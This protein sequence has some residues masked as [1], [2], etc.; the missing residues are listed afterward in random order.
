MSNKF[1]SGLSHKSF[2]LSFTGLVNI[3]MQY[4]VRAG[5]R[6]GRRFIYFLNVASL[7]RAE[8]SEIS[9]K[10]SHILS[11]RIFMSKCF[12]EGFT[13]KHWPLF[14]AAFVLCQR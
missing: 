10:L 3:S 7:P 12:P 1:S 11:P 14:S 13:G 9:Y 8:D 4:R 5:S 6:G 2:S